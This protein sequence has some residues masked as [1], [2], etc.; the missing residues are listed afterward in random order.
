MVMMIEGLAPGLRSLS[1][2]LFSATFSGFLFSSQQ[3]LRTA[4]AG[5]VRRASTRL[6]RRSTRRFPYGETPLTPVPAAAVAA[7]NPHPASV[8][9]FRGAT[10]RREVTF[11][12]EPVQLPSS[13]RQRE[14]V[15]DPVPPPRPIRSLKKAEEQE[16][17]ATAV[18]EPRATTGGLD[19]GRD[20]VKKA[21]VPPLPPLP[22]KPIADSKSLNYLLNSLN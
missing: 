14:P 21:A 10:P 3:G 15:Y 9:T 22:I 6:S 18:V 1:C 16:T 17:K 20:I 8:S 19:Q 4:T 5:L 12:L 2:L 11:E 13:V 7:L